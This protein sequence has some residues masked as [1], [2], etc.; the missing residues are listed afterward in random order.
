MDPAP[1]GANPLLTR[2]VAPGGSRV[3]Y[4]RE[5]AVVGSVRA[6]RG[7]RSLAIGEAVC[8]LAALAGAV[9]SSGAGV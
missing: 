8:S 9:V 3:E 6:S 1:Q 5:Y 2:A 4:A 7:S